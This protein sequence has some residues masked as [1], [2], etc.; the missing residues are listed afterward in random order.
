VGTRI[1]VKNEANAVYNGVYTWANATNIV[2]ST[3]TDEYGPS[4]AEQ[5][6]LNDY[7]FVTGGDTNKGSAY[8][9]DSPTGTITFGTSNISFA[10]FSS[11][12]VY[13]ANTSA[14]LVLNAQTFS[15]KVDNNTTAF[16][17]TGNIVVKTSANLTTPNIGAATGSSL[18]VT[19]NVTGGNINTGGVISA[20]GNITGGNISATSHTGSVVSVTGNITGGNLLTGGLISST[21]TI[22]SAANIS[23][24]NLV[25][26][27]LISATGNITG[28][29]LTSGGTANIATIIITTLA[30]VTSSTT[31]TSTIT[32]ALRVAGGLGVVGN[33]YGGALYSGGVSVLTINDTVDGGS[34]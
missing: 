29:N 30:N 21:G 22:T 10:Q 17:G 25:T 13:A 34:Y 14:G 18:S 9:V 6:S 20:T 7:F 1:L 19:G 24:A 4:S 5:L 11:A 33:I 27:G 23:G 32:G 31:S 26:G 12:Q 3:D 2:R 28:G 16:D 15:A 8:V